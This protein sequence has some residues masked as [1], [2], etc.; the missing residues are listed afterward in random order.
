MLRG[1]CCRSPQMLAYHLLESGWGQGHNSGTGL[2]VQGLFPFKFRFI[3]CIESSHQCCPR[4]IVL[5][6]ES[7]HQCCP[8]FIVLSIESSHQCCPRF[9]VL[10]IESSRQCCPRFIVLSIESSHQCCP[11]TLYSW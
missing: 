7:S 1:V 2:T 8:R 10:S 4:F 11:R 5:S 9:I 6:I 3:A